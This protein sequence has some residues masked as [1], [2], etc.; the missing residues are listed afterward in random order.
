ME[1]PF[2]IDLD[3]NKMYTS[4]WKKIKGSNN[5]KFFKQDKECVDSTFGEKIINETITT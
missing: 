1:I 2:I 3:R 5:Y 4:N